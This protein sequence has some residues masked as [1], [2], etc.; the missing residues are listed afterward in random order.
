MS[1]LAKEFDLVGD[2]LSRWNVSVQTGR[3]CVSVH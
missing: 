2:A 3:W 1:V